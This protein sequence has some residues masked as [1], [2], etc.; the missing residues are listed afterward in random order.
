MPGATITQ[1]VVVKLTQKKVDGYR[2]LC[3]TYRPE[4][5]TEKHGL[6]T[7][8]SSVAIDTMLT[9]KVS[10]SVRVDEGTFWFKDHRNRGR[11]SRFLRVA[12][13]FECV[14]PAQGAA[15]SPKSKVHPTNKPVSP[16]KKT[17]TRKRPTPVNTT[18]HRRH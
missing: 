5:R 12:V 11:R 16:T 6:L 8:L 1:D 3:R 14:L 15:V 9:Y 4:H 2:E 10:S 18:P 7:G 13:R 17:P